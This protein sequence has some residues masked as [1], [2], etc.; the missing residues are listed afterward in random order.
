MISNLTSGH[1][2]LSSLV[3]LGHLS[4]VSHQPDDRAALEIQV[5]YLSS[6]R[7]S[8]AGYDGRWRRS[9]LR[10]IARAPAIFRFLCCCYRVLNTVSFAAHLSRRIFP[11]LYLAYSRMISMHRYQKQELG[12]SHPV[13][14]VYHIQPWMA[15]TLLPLVAIFEGERALASPALFG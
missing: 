7:H 10:Y 2:S 4:S 11:P 14:M 5:F 8:W 12:L 6:V 1:G 13:D 3:S 9:S 15:L